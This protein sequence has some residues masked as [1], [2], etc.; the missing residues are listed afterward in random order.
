MKKNILAVDALRVFEHESQSI[1]NETMTNYELI[2]QVLTTHF[3]PLN[4]MQLQK[5]YLLWVLF[6][7]RNSKI[8]KFDWRVDNIV[9]YIEYFPTFRTAQELPDDKIIYPIE[10]SLPRKYQKQLIM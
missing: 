7:S 4:A 1:G 6:N 10:F 9:Q 8:G 2:M 5:R 3:F